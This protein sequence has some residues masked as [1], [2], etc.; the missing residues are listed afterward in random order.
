MGLLT[1]VT[2]ISLATAPFKLAAV[3]EE[4]RCTEDQRS[5]TVGRHR[6][7]IARARNINTREAQRRALTDHYLSSEELGLANQN[8]FEITLRADATGYMFFI[9]DAM[10]PCSAA[11]FSNERGVIYDAQPIR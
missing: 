11:V 6:E 8:G 3:G 1:L 7:L 2:A 5:D 10:D 9:R 4:P